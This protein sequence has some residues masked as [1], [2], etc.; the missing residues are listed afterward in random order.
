[1]DRNLITI[2]DYRVSSRLGIIATKH[3]A[4]IVFVLALIIEMQKLY[5]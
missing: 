5:E 1:M 2:A 3:Q 4:A